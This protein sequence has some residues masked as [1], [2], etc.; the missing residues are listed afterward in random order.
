MNI[1]AS[2]LEK[3]R[4]DKMLSND[5][6]RFQ[7][8]KK[9]TFNDL[10]QIF[11]K[12]NILFTENPSP[13]FKS[14]IE[15]LENTVEFKSIKLY[16]KGSIAKSFT[17]SKNIWNNFSK[18][19]EKMEKKIQ[20]L[21]SEEIGK[22]MEKCRDGMRFST[23]QTLKDTEKII[24][25]LEESEKVLG[26]AAGMGNNEN[27]G[28]DIKELEK[29][30]DLIN[31]CNNFSA[32]IDMAGR[33]QNLLNSKLITKTTKSH[34]TI[35]GIEYGQ[36]FE[37]FLPEELMLL[38]TPLAPLFAKR[39]LEGAIM[40]NKTEGELPK[41]KGPIVIAVD[42]SY[43]MYNRNIEF[44]MGFTLAVLQKAF[45]EKRKVCIVS[46]ATKAIAKEIITVQDIID[47][48]TMKISNIGSGT[49][50]N[51]ALYESIKYIKE[52]NNFHQADI[53]FITDGYCGVS[54]GILKELSNLKKEI[55]VKVMGIQIQDTVPIP[56]V[57]SLHRLS[58]VSTNSGEF[59]AILEEIV[60]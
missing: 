34:T 47:I 45:S 29:L 3:Y 59:D 56:W 2:P 44:A 18:T 30:Q 11:N 31:H 35:V 46:F 40:Q 10:C 8:D 22:T 7:V 43:S 50:F 39:Y 52:K 24:E 38:D 55:G 54:P 19:L 15:E 21:T 37:E 5:Q 14:F 60:E 12:E 36:D 58:Y 23:R 1:K 9:E 20:G 49:N 17:A 13:V 16:S 57:D 48:C 32:I 33:C 41:E 26:L 42:K 25:K 6:F 27:F 4:F 28:F 53:L 51:A